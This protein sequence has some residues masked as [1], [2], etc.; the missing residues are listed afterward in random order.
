MGRRQVGVVSALFRHPVKSLLGERP[1]EVD[2][3]ESGVI[4]DRAYALR[5]ASGRVV[6]AKKWAALFELSARYATAPLPGELAPLGITLPDGRTIR[7]EDPAASSLLSRAL[8]R[9]VVLE[10]AQSGQRNRAEIDPATVFGDVAVESLIPQ[11][12]AATLPDVF[13]LPPGTF[14]DSAPIHVLATG[15]LA[16]LRRSIGEDAQLDPRRFRPNVVVETAPQAE[17]FVEDDWLAGTLEVGGAV[18]IVA[19][20]PALRCV[21]TTHAQGDL[22]RDPRVLRS[23]A[24][25]HRGNVGVFAAISAPGKVRLGDPVVLVT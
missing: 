6:T 3:D 13:A 4:G 19:L 11:Y 10:R 25:H 16:H 17:G 14:F 5:E 8:G 9:P 7:A 2:I 23:A 12:T 24:Q 18:R 20:R 15:T 22:A 1:S 21:M